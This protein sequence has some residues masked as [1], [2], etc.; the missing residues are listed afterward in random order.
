MKGGRKTKQYHN[1]PEMQYQE[2]ANILLITLRDVNSLN[3][4]IKT[5]RLVYWIQPE[6]PVICFKRHSLM[7]KTH[8]E[9]QRTQ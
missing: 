7:V 8:T 6:D 9:N 1:Q 3:T 4:A 5:C 2:S